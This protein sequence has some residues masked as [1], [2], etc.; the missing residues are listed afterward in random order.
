VQIDT[1]VTTESVGDLSG[2]SSALAGF[3]LPSDGG[4]E[5]A[6]TSLG[7]T[8]V[9][10]VCTTAGK[11]M[12]ELLP[13]AMDTLAKASTSYADQAQ[14]VSVKMLDCTANTTLLWIG[15][16]IEDATGFANSTLTDKEFQAKW[17]P[18]K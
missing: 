6:D 7:K 18:V 12:R 2:I 11:E 4:V 16:T 10:S 17:Q 15:A 14:V 5:F 1:S 13:K 8:I 9:V 3:T